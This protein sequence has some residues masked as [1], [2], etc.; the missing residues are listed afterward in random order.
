MPES[1]PPSRQCSSLELLFGA[2]GNISRRFLSSIFF[3]ADNR[4]AFIR[5]LNSVFI[6]PSVKNL[7]VVVVVTVASE[8]SCLLRGA[9]L[10][11][12]WAGASRA[13]GFAGTA[14]FDF[15]RRT[16]FATT[17]CF[18]G[19]NS[20]GFGRIAGVAVATGFYILADFLRFGFRGT[21]SFDVTSGFRVAVD[22]L[23]E[24]ALALVG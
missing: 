13:A 5:F 24:I 14:S 1:V 15:E 19:A 10:V 8:P 21:T 23:A 22:L 12:F 3:R 7:D 9:F 16:G 4:A 2:L 11:A 6:F 20:F 17:A 18:T